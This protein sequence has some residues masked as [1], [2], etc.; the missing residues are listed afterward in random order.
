MAGFEVIFI[1]HGWAADHDDYGRFWVST[2][3]KGQGGDR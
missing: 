2:E 1:M 3:D